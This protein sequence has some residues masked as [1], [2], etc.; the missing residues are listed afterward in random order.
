V[1]APSFTANSR[2]RSRPLVLAISAWVFFVASPALRATLIELHSTDFFGIAGGEGDGRGVSFLANT[3][4]TIDSIGIQADLIERSYDII[5][6]SST[7]GGQANAVLDSTTVTRGGSGFGFYDVPF[8]F[9]FDGGSYYALLWR[10]S[11]F[12]AWVGAGGMTFYSDEPAPTVVGPATVING[13]EGFNAENF[14]NIL[15]PNLRV[16]VV[17]EVSPVPE[18]ET[19][20]LL[21]GG[22]ALLGLWKIAFPARASRREAARTSGIC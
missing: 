18:P 13:F 12:G 10:P 1:F 19:L 8:D 7:D 20:G 4:F 15:Q 5:I 2:R 6:W 22:L 9:S 14:S 17:E 3:D 16:N 11:E 21:L